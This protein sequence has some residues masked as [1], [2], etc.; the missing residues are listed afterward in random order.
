V[1]ELE[2]LS[3]QLK[4]KVAGAN[5]V[6]HDLGERTAVFLALAALKPLTRVQ[7]RRALSALVHALGGV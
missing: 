7:R 6:S 5:L 4:A 2:E 1:K 3:E